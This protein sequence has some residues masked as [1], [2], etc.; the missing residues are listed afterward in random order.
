MKRGIN[1]FLLAFITWCCCVNIGAAETTGSLDELLQQVKQGKIQES[2][3]NA[4]REKEFKNNEAQR[5]KML[6]DAKAERARLEAK[7]SEMEAQFDKNELAIG[8]QQQL[9]DKKLGSL[10]ELFGVI[11]SA[12]GDARAKFESSLTDIQFPNRTKFLTN[13]AKK[14]SSNT[15]LASLDE[16]EHLWYLLQQ[17]MTETGKVVKFKAKVVVPGGDEI[18]K[19]VI[20]VGDFNLV[21]GGKYLKYDPDTR[22]ISVLLR[23]PKPRYV[24]TAEALTKATSG[25]IPFGMDPTRGQLLGMLIEEPTWV[26]RS[27][28]QGGPIGWIIIILGGFAMLIALLK[29]ISLIILSTKVSAQKRNLNQPSENNPLGRVIKIYMDNKDIDME[30]LELKMGEAVLKE[31][32]AINRFNTLLKVIAVVAPLLGLL[33]TVT[34]MIITFQMITLFGTGD[35]KMMA[36]GISVALV[37][38]FLGLTVAIP[39]VF[40]HAIVSGRSKRI[41]E[42][43]EEQATGLVA[44]AS[45]QKAR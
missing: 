35:P 27:T 40:L 6:A 19:D 43:L 39:T 34:G 37:T 23:Q 36:G 21:S 5:E 31:L 22:K 4:A 1:L 3:E 24:E 16:I 7:S 38:T 30:S 28:T 13:L 20:R 2:A 15:Q 12:A 45:Q 9:F 14:M 29:I 18:E 33:G 10:K 42:M 26:E 11:Q 41:V 8:E 32:P 25:L 44:E 17:Q